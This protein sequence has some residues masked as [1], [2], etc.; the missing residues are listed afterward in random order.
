MSRA[1]TKTMVYAVADDVEMAAEDLTRSWSNE[2]R[3]RWAIDRVPGDPRAITPTEPAAPAVRLARLRAEHESLAAL[4]PPV[5]ANHQRV[6]ADTERRRDVL[7]H[8]LQALDGEHTHTEWHGTAVGQALQEW[9]TVHYQRSSAELHSHEG[10]LL[11]RPGFA[12][13]ASDAARRE[14]PLEAAYRDLAAQA[15]QELLP[16]VAEADKVAADLL[17]RVLTHERFVRIAHPE[18]PKRLQW[19]D[20]EMGLLDGEVSHARRELETAIGADWALDDP[21]WAP[22]PP[23]LAGRAFPVDIRD[24]LSRDALRQPGDR[25]VER[26]PFIERDFGPDLGLGL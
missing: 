16:Q 24:A 13:Q 8:R 14:A 11:R 1:R 15:R 10:P 20:R 2:T 18:V 5:P 12:R 21:S 9:K 7:R 3:Q 25:V 6:L 19:L 17:A 4:V 26:A 22:T 23:S